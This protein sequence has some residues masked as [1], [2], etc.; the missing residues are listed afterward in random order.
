[1]NCSVWA[2]SSW[3][4]KP[5]YDSSGIPFL[6]MGFNALNTMLHQTDHTVNAL[7]RHVCRVSS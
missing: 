1:M 4:K 7:P 3:R 2:R 6:T 5:I